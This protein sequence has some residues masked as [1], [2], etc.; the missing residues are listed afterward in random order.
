M[1]EQVKE[2]T[3]FKL[4]DVDLAN[5]VYRKGYPG[6]LRVCYPDT[7]N[8]ARHM[9]VPHPN[10]KLELGAFYKAGSI[11]SIR[12]FLMESLNNRKAK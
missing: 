3:V 9:I 10:A 12:G 11:K 8:W 5:P 2:K 6:R 4:S 7:T 1:T